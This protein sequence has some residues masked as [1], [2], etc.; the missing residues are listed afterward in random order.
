MNILALDAS[1]KNFSLAVSQNGRVRCFR[2][3]R[4]TKVLDESIIPAVEEI[5][6]KSKLTLGQVDGF[7]VGLGPGSFTSLRVGLS[8]VKALSMATGKPIV[9]ISSLD[10]L[11]MNVIDQPCDEICTIVDAK[12]NLLYAAFFKKQKGR[13]KRTGGYV[14]TNVADLLERAHGRTLFVG[15]GITLYR[16]QIEQAYDESAQKRKTNC[17]ALFA[18]EHDGVPQARKLAAL[19]SGRFEKK[20]YDDVD[21]L[22]PIYLYP[23]NCQVRK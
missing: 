10:A 2:N 9:G 4:L 15:D 7:A 3:I 19:A 18:D 23:A 22:V 17:R 1:T 12:R 16:S 6:K 5:L 21:K 11:A 13:L 14:L 8:T 20:E